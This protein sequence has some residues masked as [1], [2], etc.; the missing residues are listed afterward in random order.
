MLY[1]ILLLLILNNFNQIIKI[2]IM[3]EMRNLCIVRNKCTFELPPDIFTANALRRSLISDVDTYAAYELKIYENTSCQTDEYIA[4]R[5]GLIP[6]L[7][8]NT[9]EDE[10][11]SKLSLR[12]DVCDR[13]VTTKDLKGNHFYTIYDCN[14]MKLIQGQKLKADIFF[15]KGTGSDHARYSPL[16]AVGYELIDKKIK[17]AF[18]CINGDDPTIHLLNAL[19]KLKDCLHNTRCQVESV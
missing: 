4:H 14:I 6:F 7:K 12:I 15:N 19:H 2:K 3:N 13:M 17:F 10:D 9:D 18:E 8:N 11:I 1:L 5:I 16:C